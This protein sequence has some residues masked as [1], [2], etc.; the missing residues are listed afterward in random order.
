[1]QDSS[2]VLLMNCGENRLLYKDVNRLCGVR[3]VTGAS[4]VTIKRISKRNYDKKE[5]KRRI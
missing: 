1:V 3:P 2:L 4:T 5:S